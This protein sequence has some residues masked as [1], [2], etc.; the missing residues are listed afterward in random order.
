MEEKKRK[1]AI[2]IQWNKEFIVSY[3][4]LFEL[5]ILATLKV[6][7]V[8][9]KTKTNYDSF[10]EA[11]PQVSMSWKRL[12]LLSSVLVYA[13]FTPITRIIAEGNK[14]HTDIFEEQ[15][16][17]INDINF[18]EGRKSLSQYNLDY[19]RSYLIEQKSLLIKKAVEILFIL[20]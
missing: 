18:L 14:K 15:F 1:Q 4:N 7:N 11:T 2:N 10:F 12:L 19:G 17:E 6:L 9:E 16:S 13:V 5:K 20:R 3:I 8:N